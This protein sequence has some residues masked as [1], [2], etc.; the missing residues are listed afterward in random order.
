MKVQNKKT[1]TLASCQIL[2]ALGIV[3]Y[4]AIHFLASPSG[5]ASLLISAEHAAFEAAFPAADVLLA[6]ALLAAGICL[7]RGLP[8]GV[9][10]SCASGGAL[11]FL[12][13]LD[14][15][16]NLQNGVYGFA[17]SLAVLNV[18][19]NALCVGFGLC[20]LFWTWRMHSLPRI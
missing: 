5:R 17:S 10:L 3:A 7:L 6:M 18:T 2:F 9:L 11:V 12:G 1:K 15:S 19:I 13:V 20:L 14:I 4:W 16:F 8:M